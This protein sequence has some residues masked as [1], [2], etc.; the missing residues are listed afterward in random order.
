MLNDFFKSGPKIKNESVFELDS[1]ESLSDI[2]F[3]TIMYTCLMGF[4]SY[5][6]FSFISFFV[7]FM[8]EGI[9]EIIIKFIFSA[10]GVVFGLHEGFEAFLQRKRNPQFFGKFKSNK[11]KLETA[12][13]RWHELVKLIS[14]EN[15]KLKDWERKKF[16]RAEEYWLSLA[17]SWLEEA[18]SAMLIDRGFKSRTTKASG[19]GG[20]DVI[21]ESSDL[22]FLIQ[23]KGWAKP[24]GSPVVRE[25]A[26][27]VYAS[28]EAKPIRGVVV[29]P[30]G[31][32]KSA[33][34][35]AKSSSI[36]LWDAKRLAGMAPDLKDRQEGR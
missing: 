19:D 6:A 31:F 4:I 10:P 17:D 27:V 34:E 21:A 11:N 3:I 20:I 7:N 33:T 22:I 5:L 13:R 36:W 23:C 2:V 1:V 35:F 14:A 29:C 25:M 12:T 24:V 30:I 18:V 8:P 26:G 16:Q 28:K 9:P 32:T 15:I